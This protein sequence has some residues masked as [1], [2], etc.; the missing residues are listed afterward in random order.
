MAFSISQLQQSVQ[1]LI[2]AHFNLQA[3]T[4][5]MCQRWYSQC[6]FFFSQSPLLLYCSFESTLRLFEVIFQLTLAPVGVTRALC[7]MPLRDDLLSSLL[8]SCRQRMICWK[9]GIKRGIRG[10]SGTERR[11]HW[12]SWGTLRWYLRGFARGMWAEEQP[13]M[14]WSS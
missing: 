12:G 7:E 9:C 2:S 8:F 14:T 13:W 5:D 11:C 6:V 3:F 10:I 1:K 4:L